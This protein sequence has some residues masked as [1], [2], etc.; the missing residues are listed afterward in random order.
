MVTFAPVKG[1]EKVMEVELKQV[2][3]LGGGTA[4]VNWMST[5]WFLEY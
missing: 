1:A 4:S 3:V 2:V 5:H